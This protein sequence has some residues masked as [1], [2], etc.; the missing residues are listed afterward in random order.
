MIKFS[1]RMN[2]D[3]SVV[4][5]VRAATLAEENGFDQVW[6]SNDLFW[7]SAAVLIAAA[8]PAT[9]RIALGAGVLNPVSMHVAEIAMLAASLH[10][11]SAG[12]FK[13]GIGAGADRFLSWAGMQPPPAL[14]RTRQALLELRSLLAGGAVPGWAGEARIRTG[15]AD[16]P[17][18][19]GAMGPRMLELA[20]E[21][22]DG[23]LPLL[24]PPEHYVQA[25][26]RI[27]AGARRAGRQ[28]ADL[29]V[30]A[31]VWCAVANDA[32]SARRSMAAKIAYYGPSFHPSLL[33]RASV[34]PDDFTPIEQA[35]SENRFER[36]LGLVTPAMLR[37][38]IVGAA[39]EVTA[40]CTELIVAGARH[41]SFGPPLGPDI[42][43]AI[44]VLGREVVPALR[45]AS[46]AAR[47][48]GDRRN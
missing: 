4:D 1:I 24:L 40:R 36:A 42:F 28:P 5:F 41:I 25:A 17:I 30:A 3:V 23:A 35:L 44:N 34:S 19:V 45:A 14:A 8:V 46:G 12:R 33:E 48:P 13:L 16:V 9:S 47:A 32:A 7:R 27:A 11:M 6:V 20:G 31:C 37:L 29:D 2:N 22:A 43:Q 38:G 18:Y 15:R 21:V 26:A 10:E 39:G